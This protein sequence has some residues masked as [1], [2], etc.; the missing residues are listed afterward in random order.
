MIMEESLI[1]TCGNLM[2]TENVINELLL[3]IM[4]VLVKKAKAK[5]KYVNALV[6]VTNFE[7]NNAIIIKIS[8]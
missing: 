6:V 2:A 7:E 4:L 5:K 8:R 3:V 1:T